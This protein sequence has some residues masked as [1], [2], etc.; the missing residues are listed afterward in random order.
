MIKK[1][2]EKAVKSMRIKDQYVVDFM[3]DIKISSKLMTTISY[4]NNVLGGIQ[5]RTK[6]RIMHY[7]NS[8][9]Y[10]GNEYQEAIQ[11]QL[12]CVEHFLAN[13]YPIS[14]NDYADLQKKYIKAIKDNNAAIISKSNQ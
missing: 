12:N 2:L 6:N 1:K 4:I 5:H 13:F 8:D 11:H 14:A 3:A 7:I 10:F 9:D